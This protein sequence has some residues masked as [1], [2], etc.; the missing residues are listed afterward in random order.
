[1]N[2]K[3][4]T[5][6]LLCDI[7]LCEQRRGI[8]IKK[9]LNHL[10]VEK[11]Y[12]AHTLQAYQTDLDQFFSFVNK[13][14]KDITKDD[15]INFLKHIKNKGNSP[16]TANRK[17]ASIKS[18][19]R[20][21]MTE[22]IVKFNPA[23][24]VE[25]AKVD[26]TLPKIISVEEYYS[27]LSKID[28]LKHRALV[29]LLFATGIRR[30]E[31]ANLKRSAFD[32]ENNVLKVYGKNKKERLVP[33]IPET[34]PNVLLW[35]NQH[36]SEWVFPSKVN[37]DKPVTVRWVNKVIE[38]WTKKLGLKN[39]TPHSFRHAFGTYLFDNGADI[40]SIQEMMGHTSIDTTNIY[41]KTSIK[42]NRQEYIKAHPLIVKRPH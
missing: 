11:N 13:D 31:V 2:N 37:K 32:F 33:F 9:F 3:Y 30:E 5:K 22:G 15:V 23:E 10:E 6:I 27:M 40:K 41:A 42:R 25:T 21:L 4:L 18:F 36:D 8:M 34:I 39:I 38:K 1:M 16:T 14:V 35:L 17:L 29:E 12:S 7:F 28:E 24:L 26:R 19:F 20:Y